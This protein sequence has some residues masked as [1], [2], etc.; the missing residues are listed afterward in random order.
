MEKRRLRRDVARMQR[1]V[2]AVGVTDDDGAVRIGSRGARVEP[3]IRL[4]ESEAARIVTDRQSEMAEMHG[5]VSRT[6]ERSRCPLRR[7]I[8]GV[9]VAGVP[10]CNSNERTDAAGRQHRRRGADR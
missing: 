8:S 4:V 1:K 6:V 9:A 3:E 2:E 5:S 10:V 7:A